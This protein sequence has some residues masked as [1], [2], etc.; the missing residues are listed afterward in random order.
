MSIRLPTPIG[1][2][3]PTGYWGETAVSVAYNTDALAPLLLPNGVELT[4]STAFFSNYNGTACHYKGGRT[5][6]RQ[7]MSSKYCWHWYAPGMIGLGRTV[8]PP[9]STNL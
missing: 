5:A 8:D 2:P 9:I 6:R 4:Y 3:Q 7:G 1:E